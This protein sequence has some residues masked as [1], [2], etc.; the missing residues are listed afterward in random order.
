MGSSQGYL[1]SRHVLLEL[2]DFLLNCVRICELRITDRLIVRFQHC[3]EE[4]VTMC[5]TAFCLVSILVVA[6]VA[7]G[8]QADLAE[9]LVLYLSFN[10]ETVQGDTARDL[11]PQ[12]ND[13]IIHGNAELAE[14]K[15]SEAMSFD[16][17]DDFVEVPI[18]DTLTFT[19]GTTFTAQAWVKTSDSPTQNDG[20]IGTY[21]QSTAPFWNISVSGD[22]EA[23]RGKI[24]F[25]LR[26]VGRAHSVSIGSPNPL[27][28]G[29]WHYLAGVRD[30][31]AKKVRFYVDGEL[32]NELD[33]TTEDINSGQSVWI[34]EHL[35]R[36]YMGL[37]DEVKI[38][39]R[40]LS[41]AE[42]GESM[43]AS[44]PVEPSDKLATVWGTVKAVD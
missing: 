12:G 19:Q 8:A 15:Y 37:I 26:D 2:L 6:L 4:V 38:W 1:L 33:D 40:A 42:I 20:V 24:G 34:G 39:N 43:L 16:G 23:D 14:G 27:N 30:Q 9:N 13:A 3:W 21:R 10:E 28:D 32:I 7:V 11:S 41:A 18:S 5:R 22:N 36:Y 35:Q 17:V 31:D 25:N 29:E 44:A